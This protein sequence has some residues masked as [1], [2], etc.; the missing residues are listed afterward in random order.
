MLAWARR[1]GFDGAERHPPLQAG[2]GAA[3]RRALRRRGRPGR[4]QH[5][6][7]PRRADPRPQ[8]RLVGLRPGLPAGAAR[9]RARTAVVLVGAGGA[10]VAVGYGLLEQGAGARGGPRRRPRTAPTRAR[11]ASPSGSA[12]TGSPPSTTSSGPWPT[13]RGLVNATPIGML[14]H[15][16]TAVPGRPGPRRAVGLRR[17]LLPARDRARSGWR[18]S[19]AAGSCRAAG[20]PCTRRSGPSSTSPDA[21]RDAG[22]MARH[23]RELTA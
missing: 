13:R 9:R 19:A 15:P 18:A 11:C 4:G 17:R 12:T 22:R 3:A 2:G 20:W 8:H 10:G 16:G 7:L 1:L 6:G 5:R 23:F 21:C 14:G